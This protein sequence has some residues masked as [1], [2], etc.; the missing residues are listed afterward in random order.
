MPFTPTADLPPNPSV[1]IFFSGLMILKPAQDARTCEAF[2]N[3]SAAKHYLTIEVRRKQQGKPDFMMMRHVGKLNY[4]T[5][6]AD[7]FK[8]GL[9][10]EVMSGAQGVRRYNGGNS[11]TEGE[12]L[13]LALDLEGPEFHNGSIGDVD[14]LGGQPSILMNDGVFYTAALTHEDLI[15]LKQ[16]G[17]G[18][19][20]QFR[21]FASLVGANIYLADSAVLEMRWRNQGRL[22]TL[23][24]PKPAA[25]QNVSYEIYIVND[26]LYESNLPGTPEHEEFREYYK[27]LS[28]PSHQ[29]FRVK[30]IEPSPPID[31]LNEVNRGSTKAPCMTVLMGGG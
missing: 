23:R 7:E 2:I 9:F 8:H 15:V 28:V 27:I 16:Q 20:Q 26:P 21:R 1:R 22:E 14:P 3:Y 19:F 31:S 11:S 29:Q 17:A 13:D 30:T 5:P 24:L 6:T 4:T 12:K 18:T 10:L 25:A